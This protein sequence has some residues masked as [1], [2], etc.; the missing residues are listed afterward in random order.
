[1]RAAAI[2]ARLD[3]LL[4]D[5]AVRVSPRHFGRWRAL[6]LAACVGLCTV[7]EDHRWQIHEAAAY[8][9]ARAIVATVAPS[10]RLFG[11]TGSAQ[12]VSF[13][14][15]LHQLSRRQRCPPPRHRAHG[16]FTIISAAQF[17]VRVGAGAGPVLNSLVQTIECFG[18]VGKQEDGQVARIIS[19]LIINNKLSL[20]DI[21]PR[22]YIFDQRETSIEQEACLEFAS[23]CALLLT[24]PSSVWHE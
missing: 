15:A 16:I 20:T 17:F 10:Y 6:R 1:M 24:G 8:T 19:T 22:L 21:N 5:A 4:F 9:C 13:H 14:R 12:I 11:H 23:L 7:C 3:P 2:F 18:Q